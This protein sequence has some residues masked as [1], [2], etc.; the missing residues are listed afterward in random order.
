MYILKHHFK[1][2]N[3]TDNLFFLYKIL[4]E[5]GPFTRFTRITLHLNI[6]RSTLDKD[7]LI[8]EYIFLSTRLFKHFVKLSQN[9]VLQGVYTSFLDLWWNKIL[10]TA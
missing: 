5:N 3:K 6:P 9:G 7:C 2:E 4:Y 8:N 10:L 1:P